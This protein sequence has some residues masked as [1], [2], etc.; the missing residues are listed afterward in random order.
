MPGTH[1]AFYCTTVGKE[2]KDRARWKI[3]ENEVEL[4]EVI[5][6][7]I[8]GMVVPMVLSRSISGRCLKRGQTC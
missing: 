8:V 1:E 4:M 3:M 5:K 2:S 6:I 7:P